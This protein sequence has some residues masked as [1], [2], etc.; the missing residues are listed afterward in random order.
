MSNL[1]LEK[2]FTFPSSLQLLTDKGILNLDFDGTQGTFTKKEWQQ[3]EKIS[4]FNEADQAKIL[5]YLEN[6]CNENFFAED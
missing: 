1:K 4:C 5:Q 6:T 3:D 2:I